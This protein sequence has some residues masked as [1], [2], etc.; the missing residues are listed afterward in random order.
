M[1][2]AEGRRQSAVGSRRAR[3]LSLVAHTHAR[4][5][6]CSSS[7]HR[8]AA[9]CLLLTAFCLLSSCAVD[10]QR[11]VPPGAQATVERVTDEIA[12]GQDAEVYKEAAEEGR[13]AGSEDGNSKN[14]ARGGAPPLHRGRERQ[15]PPPPL[16][17]HA[18]ELVYQTRFERGNAMEKF[19]LLER[20]GQWLLAGYTVSSDALK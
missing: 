5:K 18:L 14:L 3:V 6:L 1:K 11:G 8:A 7:R 20:S 17:G 4:R 16:S 2:K 19:T 9:F 10:E 15:T 12:A 13:A